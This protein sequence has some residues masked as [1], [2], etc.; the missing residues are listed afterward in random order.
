[1]TAQIT[2]DNDGTIVTFAG[3]VSGSTAADLTSDEIVLPA[4]APCAIGV[5][6]AWTGTTAGNVVPEVSIDGA[7]WNAIPVITSPAGSASNDYWLLQKIVAVKLR[8]RFT[9]ASGTGLLSA[10]V[11]ASRG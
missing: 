8:L 3:A 6:L 5:Q 2:P 1:M 9:R 4:G 11:L 10:V 7:Q